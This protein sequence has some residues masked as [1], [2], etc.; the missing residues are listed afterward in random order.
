VSNVGAPNFIK[1]TLLDLK[2]Q[3][4][5]NTVKWE[6]SILLYHQYIGHP[7]KKIS[8]ETLELND[9][10]DQMDL[11]DIYRVFHLATPLY[12]FFS[13]AMELSPK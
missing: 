3:K 6:T 7:G 1:H 4:D 5:P 2:P 10:I 9:T 11:R 12:S 8:K 13:E